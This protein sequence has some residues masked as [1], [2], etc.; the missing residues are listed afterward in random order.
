M[1]RNP[2]FALEMIQTDDSNAMFLI[3][4]TRRNPV[5]ALEMIQT[6]SNEKYHRNKFKLSQS[7]IRPGDDSDRPSLPLFY[8]PCMSQSSIRPGDDSDA[9]VSRRTSST[10]KSRNPVFALEMI[11][12]PSCREQE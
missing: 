10:A 7:S 3:L 2:V 9:D 4:Q 5:F 11:Q 1:S 8:P 12:T 6:Y